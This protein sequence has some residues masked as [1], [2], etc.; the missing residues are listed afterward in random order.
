MIVNNIL[1][2][3]SVDRRSINLHLCRI[4]ILTY[5]IVT[6]WWFACGTVLGSPKVP[7]MLALLER[8]SKGA[9]FLHYEMQNL[10]NSQPY[11]TTVVQKLRTESCI[12]T[13]FCWMVS[14]SGM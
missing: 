1:L 4:L 10:P 3:L 9:Y 6:S 7:P 5:S 14:S 11:N 8:M 13:E 12:K 2:N